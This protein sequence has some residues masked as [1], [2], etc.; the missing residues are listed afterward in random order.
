[1]EI[2]VSPQGVARCVYGEE[3]NLNAI[4]TLQ[5]SR[6]SY[7]EPDARG[8]WWADLSPVRGPMLG[9]F[10]QRSEALD[11]EGQWLTEHWLPHLH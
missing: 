1:M 2:V 8:S 4:G 6:A 11:A 10:T 3:L 5:I 9:P 7:V